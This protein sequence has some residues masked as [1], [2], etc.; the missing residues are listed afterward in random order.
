MLSIFTS[1][2]LTILCNSIQ[3]SKHNNNKIQ[4]RHV[5][6]ACALVMIK[7]VFTVFHKQICNLTSGSTT[8]PKVYLGKNTGAF[9][10]LGNK[11]GNC[12]SLSIFNGVPFN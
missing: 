11:V 10:F 12:V 6:G 1:W 2:S 9:C 4:Y 3:N 5:L 7:R 8:R